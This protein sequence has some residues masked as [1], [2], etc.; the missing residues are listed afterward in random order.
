VK[1]MSEGE[2]L[3][4]EKTRHLDITEGVYFDIIRQ[5]TASLIAA[6]CAAGAASVSSDP[7]L[8]ETMRLL[9]EKTGLAFQIKDDLLDYGDADIGKPHAIDIREKKITL[10]LIYALHDAGGAQ[11][12]HMIGIVRHH[13]EDK[14]KVRELI[15]YV[16]S[17][18]SIKRA[19][20]TMRTLRDEAIELTRTLPDSEARR[21]MEELIMFV[22]ERKS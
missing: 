4:I 22:T 14:K 17:S 9:G 1:E 16:H 20:E 19:T 5:K 15:S 10:P 2:L 12:R 3:Q 18:G 11:R 8:I 6:S 13:S 21:S 7:G